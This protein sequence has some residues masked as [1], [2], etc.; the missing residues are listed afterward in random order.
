MISEAES[1]VMKV[2]WAESGLAAETVLERLANDWQLTT[3]KTLLNRLLSKGAIR[4]EKDARRFLYFPLVSKDSYVASETQ[5]FLA[6]VFDG[7][8]SPLFAHF[9]QH[10]S[11]KRSEREALKRLL[12]EFNDE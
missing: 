12:E 2:L 11:L 5:S 1:A 3:V 7:E 10:K 8:L 4:A 9:S 6:R